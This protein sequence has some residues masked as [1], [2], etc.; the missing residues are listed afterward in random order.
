MDI[1]IQILFV[2]FLFLTVFLFGFMCGFFPI[3]KQI[4]DK[5]HKVY[6]GI[7]QWEDV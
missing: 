6:Q 5:G 3:V 7:I 4:V 2:V 1:F